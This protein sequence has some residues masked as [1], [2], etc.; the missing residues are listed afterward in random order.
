MAHIFNLCMLVCILVCVSVCANVCVNFVILCVC[1]CMFMCMWVH[2]CAYVWK[3]EG[4][5]R[6]HYSGAIL[7]CVCELGSLY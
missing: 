2:E 3:P 4:N 6:C 1:V 7:P 5:L